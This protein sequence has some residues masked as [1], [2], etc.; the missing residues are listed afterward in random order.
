MIKK[1]M[2]K[3]ILDSFFS[4]EDYSEVIIS[5]DET[6][7]LSNLFYK[8]YKSNLFIFTK[9]FN[10][11]FSYKYQEILINRA[12][13]PI[14]YIFFERFFR[15]YK[16]HLI[17]NGIYKVDKNFYEFKNIVDLEQFSE[18]CSYSNAFNSSLILN[19]L[20]ILKTNKIKKYKTVYCKNN[21][22]LNKKNFKNLHLN[23][24]PFSKK[25]I[26]K[27][28]L[29]LEKIFNKFKYYEKIPIVGASTSDQAFHF[30]GLYL[31][32]FS[33]LNNFIL[34]KDKSFSENLRD[35]LINNLKKNNLNLDIF[36][37]D[38][39]LDDGT[40]KKITN[41]YFEF[42]KYNYPSS[43]LENLEKNFNYQNKILNKFTS[44]KIFSSDDDSTVSTITYFVLKNLN[45]NIIKF[46]HGGHYGYLKD[47][48][49]F[50][51]VEIK[52]SDIFIT[53]GWNAKIKKYDEKNYVKF[54]QLPSPLLSEKKKYFRSY[55]VS[56]N[57]KFDFVFLP[58]AV[59]PFTNDI[60]GAASFR[61]DVIVEYLNEYWELAFSLNKNNLKANVKF[62]NKVSKNFIKKNLNLLK[63]K[64]NDTFYF[65][66]HFNKG[67]S[68][69]LINSAN[70]VLFDQP[71][72]SFLE[73][74]NSG[75]P[76]M[77]YWKK[78]FCEPSKSSMQIFKQLSKVGIIHNNTKTLIE[79]YIEFKSNPNYWLNYK[80][81]KNVINKFCRR[82][83]N[84]DLNWLKLWKNY[85]NK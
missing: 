56:V 11:I 75:I 29:I 41:Y 45:F 8:F 52:N 7:N 58:Q 27:I 12:I 9:V 43:F 31:N 84:T 47:T 15:A 72:T 28:N 19:F 36:L 82:Y 73:C 65:Q 66:N 55:E 51:Q 33:R 39:K 62:Y 2:Q 74:L 71:G 79:S 59:K 85:I 81:R 24:Y 38:L 69:E 83:A 23:Y 3:K 14:T 25:I 50:N 6:K 67:L 20:K 44:K 78:S 34:I 57:R 77:V 1:S 70:V 4:T 42:I 13:S 63:K 26:I 49:G 48:L 18:R 53:N 76:T 80:K 37:A 21:Y 22:K 30:H 68:L 5:Q 16:F 35:D 40:K 32:Y 17:R 64:Y 61:R 60:Q 54:V 10:Q 46:Q